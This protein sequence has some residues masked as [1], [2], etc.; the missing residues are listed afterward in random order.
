MSYSNSSSSQP[1]K[2]GCGCGS[3]ILFL[4]IIATL[5]STVRYLVDR[6]NYSR[7]HQAYQQAECETAISYFN[8]VINGWRLV[9]IGGYPALAQKEKAECIPFQAAVDKQ[10]DGNF[11][12]A[13]VAYADFVGTYDDS[14][15]TQAARKKSTT[16]FEE[17]KPSALASNETCE[18]LDALLVRELIPQLDQNLPPFYLACGRVYETANKQQ[19]SFAMYE[20]FLTEYPNHSLAEEA[21]MLLL[22]NPLACEKNE[23]LKENDIIADRTDFMP[24]LYYG[25]GQAYKDE[26]A[27]DNAITIY[28]NFLSEFPNHSLAPDVEEALAQSIVMQAKAAGAGEIPAPQSSGSTDSGITLVIIR[29]DSPEQLRIVF[30]GPESQVEELDSCS[31]CTHYTG[32]GPLYCPEQGPIGRYTLKPGQYDVVV[33]AISDSGTTPWTGTWDLLDGDE[34]YNCFFIVRTFS[35]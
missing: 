5:Y 25:C 2:T 10:Q 22:A 8:K 31:S 11:S 34:Y 27:W 4:L 32:T 15:L 23:S 1:K 12:A 29:N 21:E 13:L 24:R 6:S 35:P 3:P 9:D 14:P 7:A 26:G 28:E 17:V 30:S 33:E 16:L 20:A 18:K 19:D